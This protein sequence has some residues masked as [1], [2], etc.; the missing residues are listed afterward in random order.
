MLVGRLR[1][2]LCGIRMLLTLGV[3]ALAVMF[4]RGTVCLSR[5]FMVFGC[6]VMFISSHCKPL[7]CL[8]PVGFELTWAPI[9]P[10]GHIGHGKAITAKS[11]GAFGA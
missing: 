2:L 1:M 5:I 6:L 11:D 8:L 10:V 9:V 7:G 4:G 3:I